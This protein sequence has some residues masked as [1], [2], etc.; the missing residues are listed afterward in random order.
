MKK[1]V[2]YY[3]IGALMLMLVE[4]WI[5]FCI[6]KD[7][8][9]QDLNTWRLYVACIMFIPINVIFIGAK[10]SVKKNV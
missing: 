1:K 2:N 8:V 3:K 6:D 5:A 9:K 4:I 7:L 10:R